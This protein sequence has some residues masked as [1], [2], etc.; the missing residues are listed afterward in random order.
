MTDEAILVSFEVGADGSLVATDLREAA[1]AWL[2]RPLPPDAPAGS[3]IEIGVTLW[4]PISGMSPRVNGLLNVRV[5]PATGDAPPVG[6]TASSD[7]DGHYVARLIVPPGGVGELGI[8]IEIVVCGAGGDCER[9]NGLFSVAGVGPPPGIPLTQI[10][11]GTILPPVDPVVAGLPFALEIELSPKADWEPGTFRFPD[12]LGLDIREPRGPSVALA[13]ATLDDPALGT[14]RAQVTLP[15]AGRFVVQ[16]VAPDGGDF[17]TAVRSI[18]ADAESTPVAP[19]G[20]ID[21][22]VIAATILI[23]ALIVGLGLYA[24]RRAG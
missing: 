11:S 3:P 13:E 18:T 23:A 24:L 8:G 22:L 2:D 6:A 9:F 4:D 19:T 15:L 16:V 20:G 7:W 1:G 14:Y 12:S 10:A 21:P 17:A 5:A